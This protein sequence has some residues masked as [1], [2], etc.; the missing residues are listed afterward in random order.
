MRVSAINDCELTRIPVA[1]EPIALANVPDLSQCSDDPT[2][3]RPANILREKDLKNEI[4]TGPFQ[5]SFGC[6]A[7][8]CLA[9]QEHL[10]CFI[11]QQSSS[12]PM[13]S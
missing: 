5:H 8:K 7:E 13:L 1:T 11:K 9:R 12:P 4:V 2:L 6:D 3:A 10:H